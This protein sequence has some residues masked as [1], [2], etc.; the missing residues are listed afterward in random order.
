MTRSGRAVF[1][2]RGLIT[3]GGWR[4]PAFLAVACSF[5]VQAALV[6]TNAG[7]RPGSTV[8]LS[9]NAREGQTIFRSHG[10]QSCHALFGMGGFLGPDL[11]NAARRVPPA[12]FAELL[13][14]GSGPMPAYHLDGLQ[15]AAVFAYLEAINATGQGTPPAPTPD[16]G[17]LFAAGLARWTAQ[18]GA[19]PGL[20]AE[21]AQLV[22]TGTCGACHR[23]FAVD[24]AI[25]APDLSLAITHLDEA[26][27]RQVLAHGRGAMPA[28]GLDDRQTDAIIEF[29]RFL[30]ANRDDVAPRKA[31]VF[32]DLQWFE[33]RPQPTR[34]AAEPR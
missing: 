5:F 17:P 4:I 22:A 33:Y 15:R 21:G 23:S 9:S 1:Q 31:G 13:Q 30:A 6:W 32:A 26:S 11:T 29:L 20:I 2:R 25:R 34:S 27:V 18:G 14:D 28:A 7:D 19:V 24:S 10:C 12:R 16:T 8:A 3:G